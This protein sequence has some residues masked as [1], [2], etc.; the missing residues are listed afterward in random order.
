MTPMTRAPIEAARTVAPPPVAGADVAGLVA[1]VV[2]EAPPPEGAVVASV[3]PGDAGCVSEGRATVLPDSAGALPAG[4][5][6][7]GALPAGAL[8]A[9]ADGVTSGGAGAFVTV[10]TEA[11]GVT[12]IWPSDSCDTG[13]GVDVATGVVVMLAHGVVPTWSWPLVAVSM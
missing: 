6:P 4:A 3:V 13:T 1:G 7:A 2:P 10:G 12:W 11:G 8:P 5:L 9:G